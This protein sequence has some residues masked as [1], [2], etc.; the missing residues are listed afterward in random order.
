MAHTAAHVFWLTAI[1]GAIAVL[2]LWLFVRDVPRS[3][4]TVGRPQLLGTHLSGRFWGYLAVVFAFT[5]GNSTDAFLLLRARQLG[6]PIALAPVLWA[7]LNFIKAATGTYGGG[8]SDRIGRKP[9]IVGGWMVY[10]AV[11]FAFGIAVSAWQAWALFAAYGVFYGM[12]EGAEKALVV[13]I[14]PSLTKGTALGWYNLAIGIGALPASLIFGA[15]WDRVG[16]PGAFM[17]GSAMALV[18][19]AGMLL[20]RVQ[21]QRL[22][23]RE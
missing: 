17:F 4:A 15:I 6:V 18:A 1:P 22:P 2:I 23:G 13:D 14:V 16:A 12:T 19:S 11:Y 3:A 5:L 9:L 10:A 21:Q 20:V 8:L 7:L